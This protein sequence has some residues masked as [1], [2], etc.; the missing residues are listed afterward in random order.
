M[1]LFSACIA[2]F[3]TFIC[4]LLLKPLAARLGLVDAPN[5]RKHHQVDTP[6]IG[7][8]A[9]FI[10]FLA[11]LL[12]LPISLQHYRAFIAGCALLVFTGLLD[13]FH[14]LSPK[15]RF[16]AQIFA[17]ILMFFWGGIKLTQFG[18]LFFCKKLN[19]NMASLPVTVIAGLGIINAINMIDGI[20][21]LA[22]TVV[23]SEL[24]LLGCCAI[25]SGQ[26]LA[27]HILLVMI[28]VVCAFLC[29]NFRWVGRSQ[30]Q[31][32]MGDAGSMFLGFALVWFLIEFSQSGTTAV[33]PVTMLWFMTL[34]LF[35]TTAVML[36]RMRRKKS[37]FSSDREH[38]HHLLSEFNLSPARI[39][40]SLG[41]INL[42]LGVVGLLAYYYQWV[43]GMMFIGFLVLFVLYFISVNYLRLQ[44]YKKRNSVVFAHLLSKN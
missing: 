33:T 18:N 11:A 37:V 26:F 40:L 7:G 10:G 3:I 22:G 36:Y 23:L 13:D 32:F 15:S 39:S 30:A 9:M 34:P 41:A 8:L 12:T 20:D 42:I 25:T 28:A 14:E 17:L 1:Y 21:G 19:L 5:S 44:L 2:F 43:E 16:F 38:L 35:D 31:V 6:L 24:L 4:I 27:A 29:L